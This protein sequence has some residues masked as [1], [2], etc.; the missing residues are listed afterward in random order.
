MHRNNVPLLFTP[1]HPSHSCSFPHPPTCTPPIP[2]HPHSKTLDDHEFAWRL[3][4]Y[5]S[6]LYS[7]VFRT[8]PSFAQY[9]RWY[10]VLYGL[11]HSTVCSQET[12]IMIFWVRFIVCVYREFRYFNDLWAFN[13]ETYSWSEIQL[14]GNIPSPRSGER[15]SITLLISPACI[16]TST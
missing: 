1:P 2:P 11:L 16:L 15:P 14:S 7:T 8:V 5:C 4:L 6:R 13:L 10:L 3:R 9:C 12:V